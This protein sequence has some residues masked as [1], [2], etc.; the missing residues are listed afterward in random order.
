VHAGASTPWSEQAAGITSRES[1]LCI[2]RDYGIPVL[3]EAPPTIHGNTYAD[4]GE[5]V[6]YAE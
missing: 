3:D 1:H 6:F 4:N 5:D 2:C